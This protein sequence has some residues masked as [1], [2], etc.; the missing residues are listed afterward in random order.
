MILKTFM[1]PTNLI[2]NS[3]LIWKYILFTPR[4]CHPDTIGYDV[5]SWVSPDT[6][7]EMVDSKYCKYWSWSFVLHIK[8]LPQ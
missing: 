6:E 3:K 7:R 4:I 8:T 1:N 2:S 5:A